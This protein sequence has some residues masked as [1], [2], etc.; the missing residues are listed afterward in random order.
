[1]QDRGSQTERAD[2]GKGDKLPQ[3]EKRD[4]NAGQMNRTDSMGAKDTGRTAGEKQAQ[5]KSKPLQDK[6]RGQAERSSQT[7]G[8]A[9]ETSKT[10]DQRGGRAERRP[11][12]KQGQAQS[13][14]RSDRPSAQGRPDAGRTESTGA[15]TSG[16]TGGTSG[17]S[18]T[19]AGTEQGVGTQAGPTSASGSVSLS[20]D[21]QTRV[22]EAFARE[23]LNSVSN[24]NFSVSIGTR[25]PASV[26]L[27]PLPA[28][29]VAI[30]PQYR[31]YEYVVV[32]DEIVIIEPRTKKIVTVIDRAGSSAST[33]ARTPSSSRI[34]L[35]AEQRRVIRSH[36]EMRPARPSNVHIEVGER[37]PDTV[38]LRTFPDVVFQDVP[39]IRPYRYFTVENQVVLVDPQEHRI[40]EVIE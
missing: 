40:V 27:R 23:R 18:G 11:Q 26:R 28:S 6:N 15:Q 38:E 14:G 13:S 33:G 16:R 37:V 7:G 17:T 3:A 32:R 19:R 9:Q 35:S 1:M 24:V 5:D 34:S 10:P 20:S 31:G 29:I 4:P 39:V 25:I 8:Q 36:A 22:R 2:R 30:V 12:D 21:Q